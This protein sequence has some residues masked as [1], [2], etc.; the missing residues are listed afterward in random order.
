[1]SDQWYHSRDGE[2]YGPYSWEEVLYYYKEGNIGNE[3]LLWNQQQDSWI[4]AKEIP[5]L[6]PGT[7]TGKAHLDKQDKPTEKKNKLAV[8]GIAG[9]IVLGTLVFL[10]TQVFDLSLFS[11][12]SGDK[13]IVNTTVEPSADDQIFGSSETVN[14]MIPGD[15]LDEAKEL[16]VVQLNSFEHIPENSNVDSAFSINLGDLKNLDGVM[17]I[18]IPY[19]RST[20]PP[21]V[22]AEQYFGAL[23]YNRA[24]NSWEQI[25]HR[26]DSEKEVVKIYTHHL[27]VVTKT[28]RGTGGDGSPMARTNSTLFLP[29]SAYSAD[30]VEVSGILDSMGA[31]GTPGDG[32]I[33]A[34]WKAATDMFS[35]VGAHGTFGQEVL[36]MG[37]LENINNA[38]GEL[39]L[40]IAFVQL[41]MELDRDNPAPAV[42]NFS[43][44]M[45]NYAVGKWGTS[46]MKIASVGVFAIDYSL[47]KFATTA[48]AQR[49]QMYVDA[50]NSYYARGAAYS[51]LP[52]FKVRNAV[53]WYRAFYKITNEASSQEE[54]ER[55][56]AQ[57]IDNYV[58]A[59][60][61]D[62]DGM[63]F[64]FSDTRQGFTYSGGSNA[65]L[66][67]RIAENQKAELVNGTLQPVFRRLAR[68]ISVE[69]AQSLLNNEAKQ[70]ADILNT[71]YTVRVRVMPAENN[72]Q[73]INIEGLQVQIE[74]GNNQ[75]MWEGVTDEDGAWEMGFTLYG[76]LNAEPSGNVILSGLG[77]D[78]Q[79]FMEAKLV[80]GDSSVIEIVFNMEEP[81][82]TGYWSGYW[83]MTDS[84][85]LEL[86][87]DWTPEQ[88][89]TIEGCEEEFGEA[90]VQM[91]AE[92]FKSL[93][94][95]DIPM[96]IELTKVD[97]EGSYTGWLI[98]H[99][100]DYLPD[101]ATAD[102]A[103]PNYFN[104]RY[105][106]GFLSFIVDL[107]D[108]AITYYRGVPSGSDII[109]GTFSAPYQG[110]QIMSGTWRVERVSP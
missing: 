74:T 107:E 18:E 69:R 1:M 16:T 25:L 44:N 20:L 67:K 73:S 29:Y 50:Y 64:A 94:D 8:F 55:L 90:V 76:L 34:G 79:E 31:N 5:A 52:G 102:A 49:E 35:I 3:D 53:D 105:E 110:V 61:R 103:E 88:H 98:V 65:A 83:V 47:N 104:A 4:P 12:G 93:A 91:I 22:S 40:G 71:V 7:E 21:G 2:Q 80:V 41:A 19:D 108:G 38:I 77:P 14:V 60:W 84:I 87:S 63:A 66:E 109:T 13:V 95:Q 37:V 48:I 106:N 15:M 86:S 17:E 26:V 36:S 11:L 54:A 82:L 92:V 100:G 57:E 33:T 62:A 9:V 10:I 51:T 59:F 30:M 97:D 58:Y 43:K 42:L 75:E 27:S 32:A 72:D 6:K 24:D 45:G 39:G 96:E 101:F 78:G 68:Q 89:N 85:F 23:Y 81:D 70:I 46:A 56:I 99:I 28:N